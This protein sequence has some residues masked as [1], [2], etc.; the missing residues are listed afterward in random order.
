MGFVPIFL[1][2]AGFVFLWAVVNYNALKNQRASVQRLGDQV[3]KLKD[4]IQTEVK[5]LE[6]CCMPEFENKLEHILQQI[7]KDADNAAIQIEFD[8]F[9]KSYE[10]AYKDEGTAI[11]EVIRKDLTKD[12]QQ[13][14]SVKK[15][16]MA[17]VKSYNKIVE[18]MPT[19]LLARLFGFKKVQF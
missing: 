16:F 10:A 18:Q 11:Q 2:L 15:E 5:Q 6:S 4:D 14:L 3:N 19:A 17:A 1:A 8:N 7:K 13:L 12:L 9:N